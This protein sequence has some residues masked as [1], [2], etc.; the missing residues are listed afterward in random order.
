MADKDTKIIQTLALLN[1]IYGASPESERIINPKRDDGKFYEYCECIKKCHT[2]VKTVQGKLEA[3][4]PDFATCC[5]QMEIIIP[6]DDPDLDI[7]KVKGELA[8]T[9]NSA[10]EVNMCVDNRNYICIIMCW[11]DIYISRET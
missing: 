6:T 4:K 10:D 9:L 2:F 5:H 3:T 8:D 1:I 11:N 7:T